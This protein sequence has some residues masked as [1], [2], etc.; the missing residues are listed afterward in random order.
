MPH[1][2]SIEFCTSPG[3]QYKVSVIPCRGTKDP[4][5]AGFFYEHCNAPGPFSHWLKWR[6][7]IPRLP[8]DELR[9]FPF[10]PAP[11]T[12]LEALQMPSTPSTMPPFSS[13]VKPSS[14]AK[15]TDPPSSPLKPVS[16]PPVPHTAAIPAI[17]FSNA[18]APPP[19]PLLPP[20]SPPAPAFPGSGHVLGDQTVVVNAP[21][22]VASA[23]P[24]DVPPVATSASTAP[25]PLDDRSHTRITIV[26]GKAKVSCNGPV[27][28]ENGKPPVRN[29]QFCVNQF[30]QKCC[31]RFQ[32]L[33]GPQC[34]GT[35]D[36]A[37]AKQSKATPN[38]LLS[39]PV[40]TSLQVPQA[41]PV[42]TV[43]SVQLVQAPIQPT[44]S[45]SNSGSAAVTPHAPT[46]PLNA[47]SNASGVILLPSQAPAMTAPV[48]NPKR[49][50]DEAHYQ[51]REAKYKAWEQR[52]TQLTESRAKSELLKTTINIMYWRNAT[53][54][55]DFLTIPCPSFPTFTLSECSS[56]TRSMLG[57]D[58]DFDKFISTFDPNR[59][60]WVN[61]TA[62]TPRD[63]SLH[64]TLLYRAPT[65]RDGALDMQT[66]IDEVM[67]LHMKSFSSRK[68]PAPTTASTQPVKRMKVDGSP[69]NVDSA[70]GITA[71]PTVAPV[72]KKESVETGPL[73]GLQQPPKKVTKVKPSAVE[74]LIID[75][76]EELDDEEL[77]GA[78]SSAHGKWPL[79]YYKGMASG[80]ERIDTMNGPVHARFAAVFG[81]IENIKF[82]STRTYY[83][84]YAAWY[85]ASPALKE[86]YLS[87][88]YTNDGLWK[89]FV[90]EVRKSFPDGKIPNLITLIARHG[91][92]KGKSRTLLEP[93]VLDDE[94][95]IIVKA[96]PGIDVLP[97]VKPEPT[98][99]ALFKP[100][101]REV[102]EI[103]DDE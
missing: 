58:D 7:D 72:I 10:G 50:M 49:P 51:A 31:L 62:M 14:P 15:G 54:I 53:D 1:T 2:P 61:H 86:R 34:M 57:I 30:C 19:P 103:S 91:K 65:V 37:S 41:V 95:E 6:K 102:I 11:A 78:S 101:V 24:V 3:C 85:A 82:P 46:L 73:H 42:P 97:Q 84:S 79:K 16:I 17:A 99:D 47:V 67:E 12:M 64:R 55:P 71:T 68:R 80:F 8:Q 77:A 92:G 87:A 74:V 88:G 66:S 18:Q 52:A 89:N 33:G 76:D 38:L 39:Q 4:Q 98:D 83:K 81:E 23:N 21:V 9:Y 59:A 13:P 56:A 27:C 36:P 96:E 75:S 26:N 45:T 35:H 29:A 28:R 48:Y 93:M 94:G 44:P 63:I 22:L 69:S 20:R 32:V 60:R 25:A 70:G 43:P 40:S 100:D 5:D 90:R